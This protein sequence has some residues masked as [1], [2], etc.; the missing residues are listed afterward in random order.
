MA[1]PKRIGK[2][3]ILEEIGRG[4]FAT[5]YKARDPNLDQ[6]VAV[7]VLYPTYAGQQGAA[8]RFL[9]EAR[10]AVRL[11]QRGIVRIYTVGEA[12]SVPYIAMEYLPGGTLAG[13]LH[14][15]PLPLDAA[16]A[17]VEQVAAAL[18]HAHKRG[19]VH[20]DVKPANV[21]FDD[22]GCAVLV[23]F[24]LVKSLAES[25]MTTEDTLLGTPTYMAP[26]QAGPNAE[27]DGRADVY[28]LGVVA[29]EMLAGRVP[30]EAETPLSVLHAH[31]HDVPPDP[32]VLNQA[33]A[34]G[35]ASVVLRALEKI[36]TERYQTA[37]AF[38]RELRRAWETVQE[39]AQVKATL[40]GLYTQAQ[41][42]MKAGHWG[43]VVNLC[44][45]MRNLDP[46]YRDVGTLLTLA[47]SRL[48]EEE[49]KR[50]RERDLE[51]QYAAAL[52][53]LEKEAYAEAVE[54]LEKIEAQAPDFGDF[55]KELERARAGLEKAQLYE[56][57][58]AKLA[59]G[60]HGEACDDLLALLK[61]DPD[62]A[63]ARARLLEA[64]EGVLARLR[65]SQAALEELGSENEALRAHVVDLEA[66]LKEAEAALKTAQSQLDS[67]DG[68]LL[69][70][71]DQDR[72]QTLALAEDLAQT[73]RPGASRVL[74]RLHVRIHPQDGK[75]MVYIP[76][77]AF[78]YG[79]EKEKI[80]LPEFWI[81]KTP[82]TNAEYA[83]FVAATGHEPPQHWKHKTPPKEIADHPVVYVSQH[84]AVVYAGWADKRL[85]T[86][87]EWE[88]AARGTDERE[89]PWGDWAK[90][91]CNTEEANIGG[92]TPVG[93]YSPDGDSPYGCVDMAGNVWE[94][95]ATEEAG[96][97][98]LRG[99]SWYNR[100]G[101][102]RCAARD[103]YL[104]DLSNGH[105]GFRCVSPIS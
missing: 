97:C 102:A 78:L 63:D 73:K 24:G 44:V 2:Y 23:D 75:V 79:D 54:T 8:Q 41:E 72:H 69:A 39:A 93:R 30:F 90:G 80:E 21:L 89:Y 61:R 62:H 22:E 70:M 59:D 53:L 48:A 95:T 47:A 35:V 58:L 40:A 51:E 71:E 13:R 101:N 52:E 10:E 68:L 77:G 92:T 42:A 38:A 104:L 16:I 91:R 64:T 25:G 4:G 45:E 19:L 18:D 83:R 50:Q 94:W 84:D 85:P 82:V 17:V 6:V 31:V 1:K 57:A 27:V 33:L 32:R 96:A 88:K 11:R 34:P 26:E 15:E 76:T 5:V 3:E 67:Y 103:G 49:Q 99:G 105:F 87:E 100:R 74:A 46:D 28:A 81:D 36:P 56:A 20:R 9:N 55:G 43:V 37:G 66:K 98:V 60:R 7:K 65:V 12:D 29:Y 14:G 86:E